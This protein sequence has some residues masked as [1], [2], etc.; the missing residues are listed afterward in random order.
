LDLATVPTVGDTLIA[1][2]DLCSDIA[3]TLK[4]ISD[5]SAELANKDYI[6]ID[7]VFTVPP[8]STWNPY[9]I[10]QILRIPYGF[11]PFHMEYFWVKFKP[12]CG[13]RSTWIPH[14]MAKFLHSMWNFH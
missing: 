3:E 4:Q 8:H 2:E 14:G 12:F 13:F 6:G 9:G 10:H 1:L 5:I 7:K 11:H